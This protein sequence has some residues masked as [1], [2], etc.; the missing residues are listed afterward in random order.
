MLRPLPMSDSEPA[1]LDDAAKIRID[2]LEREA[3]ARG[4]DSVA[5]LLYHEIGLLWEDPLKNPR[6]A[7]VA[8]QNAYRLSPQL[9]PNLHTSRRLFSQVGNWNM[10]VQL[11]DAEIGVVSSPRA[12]ASLLFQKGQILD[13]KLSKEEEALAAFEECLKLKTDDLSLLLQLE[14]LFSEKSD[15]LLVDTYRL[16]SRAVADETLRASYLTA[17]GQILEVRLKSPEEAAACYIE[18]FQFSRRDPLLLDA[19]KRVGEKSNRPEIQL[20]ALAAEAELLGEHASPVY[21]NLSKVYQK[22]GRSEDALAAL[23]AARR[24]NP[25][26]A[27]VLTQLAAIYEIQGRHE[28]LAGVLLDMANSINDQNEMVALNLRLAA[29]YDETLK[30]EEQAINRYEAILSRIPG[31]PAALTALGKLYFRLQEWDGL[32]SIYEAEIS[33]NPDPKQKVSR[34]YK[35]AEILEGRL[36]KPEDAIV[37]YRQ[38]L[39][40]QPGYLPAQQAL[41]RLYDR[42]SRYG[43]LVSLFSDE[44]GLAQT[45][46]EKIAILNKMAMLFEDRLSDLEH[47]IECVKQILELLPDSLPTLAHLARLYEKASLWNELIELNGRQAEKLGDIKQIIAL[48]QHNAEVLEE[49]VRDRKQAIATYERILSLAPSYLPALQALGRLYAQ[50]S[51]WEPLIR[52]YRAESDI[53]ATT[54][55]AAGLIFKIGELFEQRLSNEREAIAAYQEVLTLDPYNFPALRAL[56]RIYRAQGAWENVVELLRTEASSRT[57]PL[58]KANALFHVGNI[59][60]EFLNRPDQ[61]IQ[62]SREVLQF[63]PGHAAAIRALESLY[64]TT[65]NIRDLVSM[66]ERET[67]TAISP[68]SRASAYLKLSHLYLDRLKETSRASQCLEA[69]LA[70]EPNNIFALKSLERVRSKDQAKRFELRA[71]LSEKLGDPKMRTALQAATWMESDPA[72]NGASEEAVNGLKKALEQNPDDDRVSS[73]VEQAL[74]QNMDFIDLLSHYERKLEFEQR[75]DERLEFF[76][77]IADLAEFKLFDPKRALAAYDSALA[78]HPQYLPALHGKHRNSIKLGDFAT[79]RRALEQEGQASQDP[80]GSVNAFIE[81]ARLAREKLD[82]VEGAADNYRRA[83]ERDPL[84]SVASLALVELLTEEGGTGDLA[85]L[86]EQQGE[87][88]LAQKNVVEAA[89]QFVNAAETWKD[90]LQNVPSSL[91]ALDKALSAQPNHPRALEL[92]ADLLLSGGQFQEGAN[93]IAQ[94]IQQ[95]GEGRVLSGLHLKLGALY[96]DHL[97]EST[98]AAAH[99]QTVLASD[100]GNLEALRRLASLYIASRN[101]TGAADTLKRLIDLSANEPE[102]QAQHSSE[103]AQVFDEGFGDVSQASALYRK[104]LELA[105]SDVGP[106]EKLILLAQRKGDLPELLS[107]LED[108]LPAVQSPLG[109]SIRLKMGRMYAKSLQQPQ[110]AI[111]LFRQLVEVNPENLDARIELA[112]LLSQN[113]TTLAKALVEHRQILKAEPTLTSSLHSLFQIWQNTSQADRAFCVAGV[114]QFLRQA[115][116]TEITF[117]AQ[118][119]NRLVQEPKVPLSEDDRQLLLHPLARTEL[120]EVLRAVGDQLGKLF[121]PDFASWDVDKKADKMKSD[122][123]MKQLLA[124]IAKIFQAEDF[125]VYQSR[126]GWTVLE[127]TDPLGVF[128]GYEVGKRFT[129]WEQNF[130]FGRAALGLY[131]KAAVLH[132][133]SADQV[134]DILGNSIRA[135]SPG[136]D[137]LGQDD[138]AEIKALRKAYSRKAIKALETP[139]SNLSMVSGPLSAERMMQGFS[140]S[141]DRAGLLI[142]GDVLAGLNMRWREDESG[143]PL[144]ESKLDVKGPNLQDRASLREMIDFILSEDFFKLR[145]RL[146]LAV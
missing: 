91:K 72:T 112:E 50:E 71:K 134:A 101:W 116:Q 60:Q 90:K 119:K 107:W 127:T 138:P 10:V 140:Y 76:L 92:K 141:S 85:A 87:A 52:M 1:S 93:L 102:R 33:S 106:I 31:H 43:E 54:D 51:Q 28:D 105:P 128:I 84:N 47:A 59:W 38:C 77:R 56:G 23:L 18:A 145:E 30:Q 89:N 82:D 80:R 78:L 123:P 137:G 8:Y 109:E 6:N 83:L 122:N 129:P 9:L 104:A 65:D 2:A 96:Q 25:N 19:V 4:N 146:R 79:A 21:L 48:F 121:P 29:L 86:Q 44:L 124:G 46:D 22:L 97:S 139:A 131:Y 32:L 26:D 27:L 135:V 12:Q 99:L 37:R 35:A 118:G 114:L 133:I 36:Q 108:K 136:Y 126:K 62:G 81:A 69:V 113:P 95:G 11:L 58:E 53:A 132:K 45:S 117:Y 13:E 103:L 24:T 41:I 66:L 120:L 17:A 111:E 42:Q 20:D 61:A 64:I 55:H 142:C 5:A 75:G 88:H 70:I 7:A 49:K 14:T 15:R 34:M 74:R 94:R 110:R 115:S 73:A 68:A 144:P 143:V 3:K 39:Q 130:L 67:Q 40:L 125:D 57:D 16:L 63:V 98:R 100:P